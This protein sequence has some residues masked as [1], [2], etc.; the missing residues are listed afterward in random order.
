[1]T[2][3]CS[4]LQWFSNDSI[5]GNLQTKPSRHVQKC[6]MRRALGLRRSHLDGA[7][8]FEQ[9]RRRRVVSPRTWRLRHPGEKLSVKADWLYLE[10]VNA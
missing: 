3:C 5:T 4:T 2:R 1:M 8:R 6:G 9:K 10:T 7:A